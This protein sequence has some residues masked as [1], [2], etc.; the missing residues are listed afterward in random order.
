[1]KTMTVTY[2]FEPASGMPIW[3]KM[4][5]ECGYVWD[6]EGDLNGGTGKLYGDVSLALQDVPIPM[7]P[8]ELQQC[9]DA[10]LKG[11]PL[12]CSTFDADTRG[13]LA[14]ILSVAADAAADNCEY[15]PNR[16]LWAMC[17]HDEDA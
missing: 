8:P 3:P 2:T 15:E 5:T 9:F 10:L 16:C 6:P 17:G 11:G 13:L 12:A 4:W 14:H 7:S 1:M